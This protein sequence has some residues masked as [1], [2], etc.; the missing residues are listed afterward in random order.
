M[1]KP[2]KLAIA[3]TLTIVA[4]LSVGAHAEDCE[5][6][7]FLAGSTVADA[8]L[9][10]DAKNREIEGVIETWL[11]GDWQFLGKH[12]KDGATEQGLISISNAADGGFVW[13]I[14]PAAQ[15]DNAVFVVKQASKNSQNNNGI[16]AVAYQFMRLPE[17]SG[18]FT[19]ENS[20]TVND[21]SH[22]SVYTLNSPAS[23]PEIDGGHAGL[24]LGLLMF[25]WAGIRERRKFRV[26]R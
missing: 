16:N 25:V 12:E 3:S 15:V 23:V 2:F 10:T 26:R 18:S 20:F 5:Q 21:Y 11:G 8:C 6:S 7:D 1:H 24:S 13:R 9:S 22:V 14:D 19:T 17:M 4:L